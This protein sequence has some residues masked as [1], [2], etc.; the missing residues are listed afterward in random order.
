MLYPF[1]ILFCPKAIYVYPFDLKAMDVYPF[2]LKTIDVY[3][4]LAIAFFCRRKKQREL[5]T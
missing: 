5:R 4:F 1:Y 2:D 3:P